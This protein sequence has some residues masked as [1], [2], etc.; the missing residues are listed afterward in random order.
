VNGHETR[1]QYQQEQ[2]VVCQESEGR[3]AWSLESE[4]RSAS[5]SLKA[6]ERSMLEE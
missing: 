4:E 2:S 6:Y 1:Q 5:L 3:S